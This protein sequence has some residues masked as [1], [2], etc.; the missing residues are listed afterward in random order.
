MLAD[1]LKPALVQSYVVGRYPPARQELRKTDFK[2]IKCLISNPRMAISEIA[3]RIPVS[4]KTVSNRLAKM[5]ENQILNFFVYT[6]PANMQG[7]VRFGMIIRL[8]ENN[9]QKA[10]KQIYEE[11]EK[12]F[13][14]AFPMIIQE[15][16][17]AWQLIVRS[18]FEID[19]AFKKIDSLD[20]VKGTEVFIPF[21]VDMYQDWMM[22]E[23]DNRIKH[24]KNGGLSI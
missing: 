13:V 15:D 16:V 18:I 11:L 2:I 20:G 1:A 19:P 14:M 4:S 23:I 24:N 3:R 10:A 22:K 8:E 21:R 6:E 5:K 9:S 17:M 7:Y 12:N